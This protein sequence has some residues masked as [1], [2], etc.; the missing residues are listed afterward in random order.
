LLTVAGGGRLVYELVLVSDLSVISKMAQDKALFWVTEARTGKPVAGADIRFVYSW[1]SPQRGTQWEVAHGRTGT[2][3]LYAAEL[4]N[5]RD[6]HG[7]ISGSA[8][9]FAAVSAA[10]DRQAFVQNNSHGHYRGHQHGKG[11]WWSY[12][13]ADRPAYRPDEEIGFKGIVRLPYAGGFSLPRE[14]TVKAEIYDARGNK[15]YEQQHSINDFGGFDGTLTLDEKAVLGEYTLRLH[16]VRS[17]RMLSSQPLFR[18]EEYKLPEFLVSVAPKTEDGKEALFRLGD[19][20]EMEVDAQYYFG[21]AVSN[22]QVT[23]LVY[24]R[25]YHHSYTPP[26]PY[27][28]Y[29]RDKRHDY[30]YGRRGMPHYHHHVSERLVTQANAVTDDKGRASFTIE[31]PEDSANDLEYR[32]EVRVVDQSRREI[33]ASETVKVTK[34]SFFAYLE[35]ERNLYRPGDTVRVKIKTMTANGTPVSVEGKVAVAQRH[36]VA[37]TPEL[38]GTEGGYADT[39]SFQKFT[40]TDAK[41]EVV[42][43][44]EPSANG[45]YGVTFTGFDN[46]RE[47]STTAHVFVSDK[48]ATDIGYRYS[49]LQI[50]TEKDTYNAGETLRAMIVAERPDTWVLLTQES[51]GIFGYEMLYLEGPVRMVEIPVTQHFMPNVFVQAVS[52]DQFQLKTVT[53][54]IIVPPEEQFLNVKI[55]SD[56]QVYQPQEDGVFD[57]LV[58]DRDGKPV[59]AEVSLGLVDSAVYYIQQEYAPDIREFFYGDKRPHGVQ[60]RTAF[61]QRQFVHLVRDKNGNLV[62]YGHERRAAEDSRTGKRDDGIRQQLGQR[63]GGAVVGDSVRMELAEGAPMAARSA[64]ADMGMAMD[65]MAAS[66]PMMKSREAPSVVSGEDG[67]E[68]RVRDDF[69]ST[70]IWQPSVKTGADGK[71]RVK[72]TFPDSLTTWRMTARTV[73]QTTRVGNVTHEVQSNKPL[74]VRLQAPRFFTERDRVTVSALIDNLTEEAVTVTPRIAVEGLVVDGLIIRSRSVLQ[75]G[76]KIN[77]TEMPVTVPAGGQTRVEWAVTA[78]QAGEAV[79]TVSAGQ[80]TM[81]D[82]MRRSYTV[83]PHGIEK[84]IA[85]AAVLK[86]GGGQQMRFTVP[87]ER[88]KDSTGLQITLSPSLAANMLDAL[89]YLAEFPYGCVEQTMSRF[90]PAVIVRSTLRETGISEK[91][92]QDYINNVL[93]PR[94]DPEHPQRRTESTVSQLDAMVDAGLARIYDMQNANGGWGWWKESR[95]DRFMSAYVVW[96]LALA[97]EAG[98]DVRADVLMRGVAYLQREL[99]QEQDNPDNLAWMLHALAYAGSDSVFDTRMRD[100]LWEMRDRLNPYTRALFALSEQ[101]RGHAERSRILGENLANGVLEDREHGTAR[102]GESGIHYRWSEGG[103]EATAFVIKALSNIAQDSDYLEPAVKWLTLNRRGGRWKNTRDTAIA[104]LALSDYLKTSGEL[105]ADYGYKVTLN[106]RTIREGRVDRDNIFTFDRIIDIPADAVSDGENIVAVE[107]TGRGALYVSG[108]LTYFTLEEPITKAGNEIYV[109]RKYYIQSVKETLMQGYKEDWKKLEDGD[110]VKSGDRIRVDVVMEAKNH[111]EYL[112]SEDY[113]PAGFESTVLTS[114]AGQAL[115]LDEDGRETGRTIPL[116][117]EFRDRHAAFF[118]DK[119]PQGTYLIRYELRAEVPGVFHAM[120]NQSHAMYVPEIRANSD[121]M[122]LT[123]ED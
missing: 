98:I 108:Y 83:I 5:A 120:P 4:K 123:V 74:M 17:N 40:K 55:I 59:A 70:V 30:M 100:R 64:T 1:H 71:A 18:L 50:I 16:D 37:P 38:R 116:Y 2:D 13:F 23:Y 95:P 79:I 103:V 61:Q 58:T 90:L 36:W 51:D 12:A 107:M 113:K 88:I 76:Q 29:Y 62:P 96:G 44:F 24:Q 52:V 106:G 66:P 35:P 63:G 97:R 102:W 104:I 112:I 25:D 21:G 10:G 73:T 87:A 80:G 118:I 57:I 46:G 69:R 45:Y 82:A 94:G 8:T 109:D 68:P 34:N 60:T 114:G 92:V 3:G 32:I 26:K 27:P 93:T 117:Q 86:N 77:G 115:V 119:M 65:E 54:E 41:G 56:K 28:W 105:A 48:R 9:L 81:A 14:R 101:R 31:T 7:H 85:E 42:F 121:E 110:T 43:T 99:V 22:A 47:V 20:V 49:G 33:T 89:P 78:R 67:A 19:K 111:Y 53:E 11:D 15:V 72:V 91:D 39:A 84:F 75:D 122:R 6:Q